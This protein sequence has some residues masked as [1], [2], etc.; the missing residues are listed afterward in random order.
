MYQLKTLSE[1]VIEEMDKEDEEI[2]PEP[3]EEKV[4]GGL[5]E[6]SQVE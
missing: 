2:M 5:E 3:E 6:L 1:E 4:E